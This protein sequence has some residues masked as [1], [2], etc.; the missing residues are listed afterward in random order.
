MIKILFL[1]ANP[2]DTPSLRLDEEIRTIDAKIRQA[3]LRDQFD[4]T[5][6][7]AVRISDL[8]DQL[9]RHKPHIVHFSGHGNTR[10]EIVLKNDFGR[11]EPVS[12]KA[13]SRLFSL[14]ADN[15]RCVVLNACY[16]QVQAQ[17]IAEHIEC[18]VGMSKAIGDTAAIV[19]AG[20]FYQALGYG[21]SIK[22]AFDLACNEIE[23][24]NLRE[25]DTPQLLALR[26]KPEAIILARPA[27]LKP[28]GGIVI[29]APFADGPIVLGGAGRDVIGTISGGRTRGNE[30][31]SDY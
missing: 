19:F 29:N 5:Q 27:P 10:S 28:E 25:E 18:V 4:I 3:D 16:S 1:A 24:R 14:L 6:H 2:L 26:S 7:W 30:F 31:D 17:A 15:I 8:Q 9:L 23:L 11:S 22:T 13:L 21:R 12:V 20:S